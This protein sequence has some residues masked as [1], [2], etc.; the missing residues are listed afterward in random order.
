MRKIVL[1]LSMLSF[2]WIVGKSQ[3]SD[4]TYQIIL[5]SKGEYSKV[6][7]HSKVNPDNMMQLKEFTSLSQLY[8]IFKFS[9]SQDNLTGILQ[10]EGNLQ[11]YNL[12]ADSIRFSFQELYAQFSFSGR[13]FIAFGKKRLDWGTGMIWN[14]TNFYIQKDPLRTQNRLEGI[15][16]TS[17]TLLLPNGSL[18]AYIFPE[19][20]LKDFSYALKYD[21]YGSRID[22]SLTFLQYT[23]YQQFGLDMSYGGDLFTAYAEGVIRNYSKS[24]RVGEGGELITPPTT[25]EKFWAEAVVGL[26][27]VCNTHISTRAEY[28]FREDYLG[29]SAINSYSMNL[30]NNTIVFDPISMG[31]HTLFASI[32]WKELYERLFVQMRTFYDPVSAQWMLSPLFI[33][34]KNN[35]QVELWAMIY[36]NAFALFDFQSSL[37]LSLHF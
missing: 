9:H 36:N 3:S 21:Y 24:Y 35:F 29:R 34:K 14:P 22:A 26:S 17:Y 25:K 19:S 28:R 4:L 6:D 16:Q 12:S 33:W 5:E 1:T 13:H 30:P 20:Q 10:V 7:K 2:L 15:F 31:K 37:L 8:P 18:Q 27:V 32:E 23:R 11:N